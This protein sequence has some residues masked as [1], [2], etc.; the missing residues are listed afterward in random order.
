[1]HNCKKSTTD[2][3]TCKMHHTKSC[4]FGGLKRLKGL[5]N[6]IGEKKSSMF[7]AFWY[8]KKFFKTITD[9]FIYQI[10]WLKTKKKT[11][12]KPPKD[13]HSQW[14]S[15]KLKITG[16]L[17]FPP[18]VARQKCFVLPLPKHSLPSSLQHQKMNLML[19]SHKSCPEFKVTPQ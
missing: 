19:T 8:G 11:N 12:P 2:R 9:S 3:D 5:M 17:Q 10:F 14:E 7:S 16:Q 6:K 18:Y 4:S 15:W 1:M 13:S